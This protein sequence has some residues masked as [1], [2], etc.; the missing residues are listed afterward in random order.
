M[1]SRSMSDARGQ[2]TEDRGKI[3]VI[4]DFRLRNV[5]IRQ[6]HL[7]QGSPLRLPEISCQQLSRNRKNI[8]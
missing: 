5:K 7:K 6:K 8:L 3:Q 4:G 1:C 2:K